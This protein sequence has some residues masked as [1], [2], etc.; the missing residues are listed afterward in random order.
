LRCPT[1]F[2][3]IGRGVLPPILVRSL[4]RGMIFGQEMAKIRHGGGS[5]TVVF[6][7]FWEVVR[8]GLLFLAVTYQEVQKTSA[9]FLPVGV[10]LGSRAGIINIGESQTKESI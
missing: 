10:F 7:P 5:R 3:N 2:V 9:S 4:F 1:A 8:C 6:R